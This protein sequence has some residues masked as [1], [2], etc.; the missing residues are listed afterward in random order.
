MS[1]R[2]SVALSVIWLAFLIAATAQVRALT[3]IT[4]PILPRQ[5]RIGASASDVGFQG[6]I[7]VKTYG[8]TGDGSRDDTSAIAAAFAAATPGS[9]VYFP[10]GTYKVSSGFTISVPITI[11][12]D[13]P[14]G[15]YNAA[16]FGHSSWTSF[17]EQGAIIETSA[18]S[19]AVITYSPL[20]S[21]ALNIFH[22][23]IKGLG[24]FTTTVTGIK[25]TGGLERAVWDD[26]ALLN[27]YVGAEIDGTKPNSNYNTFRLLTF[28][29]DNT[30]L[31][32]NTNVN[33]NTF[34]QTYIA[35][36]NT[37]V[38]LF[39]VVG[40]VFLG[41]AIQGIQ[42]GGWGFDLS[43]SQENTIQGM[44]FENSSAGS[45]GGAIQIRSGF[46]NTI[47]SNHYS[48]SF[49]NITIGSS[50]NIIIAPVSSGA[51]LTFNA[52]TL[53]NLVIGDWGGDYT[54]NG[55]NIKTTTQ[56]YGLQLS[57]AFNAKSYIVNGITG[58]TCSGSPTANFA[59]TGGIVT[60]C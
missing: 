16:V 28:S 6:Y 56:S 3:P 58:V 47:A 37:G 51:T 45:S 10:S 43:S 38:S 27:L 13:G 5:T 19:G 41:G 52:G 57:Q 59:V 12:G 60:H 17:R 39:G 14:A 48:T 29:G 9:T 24:N 15:T 40:N 1:L 2:R 36:C 21:S 20:F 25:A 50:N 35:A 31:Y 22:L 32:L 7:N 4:S 23:T 33:A 46:G 11:V 8:A 44:Y 30:A 18:T 34:I 53:R 49:D 42:S 26:V 54:D 55:G